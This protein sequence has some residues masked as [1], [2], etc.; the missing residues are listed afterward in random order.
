MSAAFV[1]NDEHFYLK[2]GTVNEGYLYDAV[3]L[4]LNEVNKH[5]ETLGLTNTVN[6]QNV[7]VCSLKPAQPHCFEQKTL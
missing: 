2:N 1:E 4:T 5:A 7:G 3:H 6:G